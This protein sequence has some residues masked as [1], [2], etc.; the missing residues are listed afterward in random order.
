MCTVLIPPGVNPM[1][2]KYININ[3]ININ[4]IHLAYGM[5]NT[6]SIIAKKKSFHRFPSYVY[7]ASV[8]RQIE[9]CLHSDVR[10][11]GRDKWRAL[12][13]AVMNLWFP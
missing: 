6:R 10:A 5:S 4:T 11:K 7:C 2:V 9:K 13:N 12:V 1:A 3:I 8:T